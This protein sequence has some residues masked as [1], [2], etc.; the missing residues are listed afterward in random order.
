MFSRCM[1]VLSSALIA[2][3]A[4]SACTKAEA[5]GAQA[6][7]T[8]VA[9]AET[10]APAE[11]QAQAGAAATTAPAAAADQAGTV[12]GAGV[13]Q[14]ESVAMATLLA[15]PKAYEGKTVRVEG[16]VTDVCPKRGCWFEMA[17]EQPGQKMRFKVRDG[18]MVFPMDAKGKYALAEGVVAVQALSLEETR[19]YLEYQAR[20]YGSTV[21]PASV[22]EP[23]TIVRLDGTGALV[24]DGK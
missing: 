2:L 23:M 3:S 16:T 6:G 18:E 24:R 4:G 12:Y 13:S 14:T 10:A 11:A 7:A 22:T 17:G 9:Q 21:D 8:P 20:E 5:D 1:A 15:D 19:Q